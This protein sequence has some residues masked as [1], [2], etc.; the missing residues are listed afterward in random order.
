MATLD[1][2]AMDL[3]F[4]KMF[5]VIGLEYNKEFVRQPGWCNKHTW[6]KE[7]EKESIKWL[8]A[9]L[10]RRFLTTKQRARTEAAWFNLSFGW[11]SEPKKETEQ[12]KEE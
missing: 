9:F 11:Q 12:T 4:S 6:N 8:E 5:T 1:E 2:N 10:Y 7:Q 3:I